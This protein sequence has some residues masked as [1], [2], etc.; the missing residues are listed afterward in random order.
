MRKAAA[1]VVG[2]FMTGGVAM[3][4]LSSMLGPLSEAAV[5]GLVGASLYAG[6]AILQGKMEAPASGLAKEA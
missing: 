6:S 2:A 5:L 4:M 3:A 1:A